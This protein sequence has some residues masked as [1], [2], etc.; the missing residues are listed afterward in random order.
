MSFKV[1][2][3][4]ADIETQSVSSMQSPTA[5]DVLPKKASDDVLLDSL[6]S[7]LKKDGMNVVQYGAAGSVKLAGA[8]C[9]CS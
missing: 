9:L 4:A 1:W 6:A 3:N 2:G 8:S 5:F 7:L